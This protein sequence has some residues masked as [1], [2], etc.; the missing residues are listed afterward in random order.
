MWST[1]SRHLK[2]EACHAGLLGPPCV[3]F[4]SLGPWQTDKCAA[5]GHSLTLSVTEMPL[6]ILRSD[7]CLIRSKS[8]MENGMTAPGGTWPWQLQMYTGNISYP[9][10]GHFLGPI[11]SLL[12]R[13]ALKECVTSA[14]TY[15]C[16]NSYMCPP[17]RGG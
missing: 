12:C 8:K 15:I 3:T 4:P 16:G 1:F 11:C 7:P 6:H 2:L 14:S 9:R 13:V 10:S 17:T 5:L